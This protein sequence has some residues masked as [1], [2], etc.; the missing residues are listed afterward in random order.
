[1]TFEPS[2]SNAAPLRIIAVIV[3]YFPKRDELD[4]LL[5]ALTPQVMRVVVVDN[6][7]SGQTGQL[8]NGSDSIE[9]AR[10]GINIGLSAAQNR[11]I[12]RARELNATHVVLF[13]QD[14]IP[15]A[16]M[17][18]RLID[19]QEKLVQRG[20][21]LAAVGPR[22]LDR[23]TGQSAPFVRIGWTGLRHVHSAW[24]NEGLIEADFL[25]ASG[26]LIPL[27]V[28]DQLGGMDE[29]LFIDHVDIEFAFRAAAR[30]FRMYG[31]SEAILMHGLGEAKQRVWL[32]KWWHVPVHSPLRN[33]YFARN[34]LL[35]D[36][37]PYVS[38]RWRVSSCLR[39]VAL[40]TCF[41]TQV[42]PRKERFRAIVA[43][44]R[45]G[46]RGRGGPAPV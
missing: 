29:S 37:R 5:S 30:G 15:A 38:W 16:D 18:K 20:V 9:Q 33:Y 31:I 23:H 42:A 17:I 3:T 22:W 24:D 32:G 34:T 7:P 1:M 26:S 28:L 13:D 25:I 11:G 40:A 4:A 6:T 27:S 44:L 8:A 2:P 10:N 41:V 19:A 35:V 46:M 45:D 36:R 12:E 39:L 14:S 21:K 43:G